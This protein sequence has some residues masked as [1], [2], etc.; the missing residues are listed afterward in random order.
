MPSVGGGGSGGG[1]HGGGGFSGGSFGG[2]GYHGGGYYGGFFG[3]RRRS[4]LGSL[5]SAILSP[6]IFGVIGIICIVVFFTIVGKPGTKTINYDEDT[7]QE[8][9]F[10]KYYELYG[11]SEDD[12]LFVFLASKNPEED[13]YYQISICGDNL[14]SSVTYLFGNDSTVFGGAMENGLPKNYKNS[15]PT[16]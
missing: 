2:G 3:F 11:N 8:Y 12:V 1:F 10:D 13:G 7:F 5:V 15:M 16:S 6:I 9:A 4:I 14:R